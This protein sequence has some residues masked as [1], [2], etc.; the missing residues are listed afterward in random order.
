MKK[1]VH[2]IYWAANVSDLISPILESFDKVLLRK[3][4]IETFN[5]PYNF[6]GP[7]KLICKS[8]NFCETNHGSWTVRPYHLNWCCVTYR[9]EIVLSV[10][11]PSVVVDGSKQHCRWLGVSP[12]IIFPY[13]PTLEGW[14]VELAQLCEGLGDLLVWLQRWIKHGSL[15]RY[16]TAT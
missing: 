15:A 10:V 7:L 14:E 1:L 9:L 6:Y 11:I 8:Y 13:L 4:K 12:S 3:V 16:A 2:N 5:R